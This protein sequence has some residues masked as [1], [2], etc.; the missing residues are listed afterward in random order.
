MKHLVEFLLITFTLTL[1]VSTAFLYR[2]H[3]FEPNLIASVIDTTSPANQAHTVPAH[4]LPASTATTTASTALVEEVAGSLQGETLH[5]HTPLSP[6]PTKTTSQSVEKNPPVTIDEIALLTTLIHTLTNQSRTSN[7]LSPYILDSAL[8]DFAK[9]RSEEMIQ[10]DYFSHTSPTGCDVSCNRVKSGY[11]T[12][13][14][15]ENLALSETY[16]LFTTPELA[17][18]FIS[19]WLQSNTHRENLLSSRYTRQGIGVASLHSTIIVTV[20]FADPKQL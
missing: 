17:K 19:D 13:I 7:N 11:P 14:W 16:H 5:S 18:R 2:S 20:V 9:K 6:T 3:T 15:G 12:L 1:L 8:S 4:S 10:K